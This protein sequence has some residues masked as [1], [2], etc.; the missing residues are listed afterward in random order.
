MD[1]AEAH[2]FLVGAFDFSALGGSSKMAG[3]GG[4]AASAEASAIPA[5]LGAASTTGDPVPDP[6]ATTGA[7]G[8]AS[9]AIGSAT[10]DGGSAH[11]AKPAPISVNTN[12]KLARWRL[13][14][15]SRT[16]R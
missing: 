1:G 2:S 4:A 6:G 8:G 12:P 11:P 7:S 13:I 5:S 10:A 3:G 9:I 15:S 16:R 14:T